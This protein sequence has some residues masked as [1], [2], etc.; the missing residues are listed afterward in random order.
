MNET[1]YYVIMEG[2]YSDKGV[3]GITT[4]LDIAEA[5]CKV[6]NATYGGGDYWIWDS[7]GTDLIAD[8][9]FIQRAKRIVTCFIYRVEY[10]I[11]GGAKRWYIVGNACKSTRETDDTSLEF[12]QK[13]ETIAY[14]TVYAD[15]SDVADKIAYDYIAKKNA[16]EIGL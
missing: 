10:A 2:M 14:L 6:N 12:E 15:N 3:V 9:T 5:Y 16:E 7:D 8:K 11:R 1:K 13:Y 4:S